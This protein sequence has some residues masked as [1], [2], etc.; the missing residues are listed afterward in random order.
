MPLTSATSSSPALVRNVGGVPTRREGGLVAA[1]GE[2][3]D[4]L[5]T[6][7]EKGGQDGVFD[8]GALGHGD[9][10]AEA[11]ALEDPGGAKSG[12]V[13]HVLDLIERGRGQ[14]VKDEAARVADVHAV[15]GQDVRVGVEPQA[16][17]RT[18]NDRQG[19]EVCLVGAAQAKKV[20][21]AR[22]R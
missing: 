20:F 10:R 21:F 2:K 18:L 14:R 17:T 7:R 16:G 1:I 15:E 3:I 4:A 22:M 5:G 11:E 19:L 13:G 6:G 12:A 9:V 8:G